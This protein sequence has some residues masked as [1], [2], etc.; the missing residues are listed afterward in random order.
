MNNLNYLYLDINAKHNN[1]INN[2]NNKPKLVE[3]NVQYFL[4]SV[5]NNCNNEKLV[6]YNKYYGI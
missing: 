3:N 6:T 1:N 4:K 2:I 5:L